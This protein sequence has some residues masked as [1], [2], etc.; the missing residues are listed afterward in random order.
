MRRNLL[1]WMLG[2]EDV[3]LNHGQYFASCKM[4]SICGNT[5]SS[6]GLRVVRVSSGSGLG[7]VVVEVEVR[8]DGLR[9]FLN[10]DLRLKDRGLV[11]G[12]RVVGSVVKR[13][14]LEDNS[15]DL[16]RNKEEF[17]EKDLVVGLGEVEGSSL[18]FLK[19]EGMIKDEILLLGLRK[20]LDDKK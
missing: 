13:S 15:L 11:T 6:S 10:L 9:M 7:V 14:L 5:Y 4:W 20:L 1:S 19:G 16:V 12:A 8:E 18:E 17:L 2:Y 3:W